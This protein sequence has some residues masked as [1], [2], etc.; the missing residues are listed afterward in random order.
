MT[1]ALKLKISL[2]GS[3]AFYDSFDAEKAFQIADKFHLDVNKRFKALS[4]G[5]QSIFKLT[6]ALA[7]NVPYLIFD[8]PVLGLGRQPLRIV[9]MIFC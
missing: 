4:K 8:E 2:S 7:L 1:Q 6:A 5:Y 3:T 9:L